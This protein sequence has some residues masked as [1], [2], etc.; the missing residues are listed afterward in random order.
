MLDEGASLAMPVNFA[1]DMFP[2]GRALKTLAF[3]RPMRAS[4][5]FR[6]AVA[7]QLERIEGRRGALGQAGL[8]QFLEV[9]H[10][11]CGWA[12][13]SGIL[14]QASNDRA[15]ATERGPGRDIWRVPHPAGIEVPPVAA[16]QWR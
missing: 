15:A 12:A 3:G 10:H 4:W 14:T 1:Q 8:H 9:C 5:L 16:H 13:A 6:C 7:E 2:R 11:Q